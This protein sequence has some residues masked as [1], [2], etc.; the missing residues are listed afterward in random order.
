MDVFVHCSGLVIRSYNLL[1]YK[2]ISQI[3]APVHQ[4][5]VAKKR[6][7]VLECLSAMVAVVAEVSR[8]VSALNVIPQI[9]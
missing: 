5:H 4:G 3:L 1:C 8:K 7:F 2:N 9:V 6:I